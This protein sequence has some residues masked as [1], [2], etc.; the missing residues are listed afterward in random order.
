M[1]FQR[2][3]LNEIIERVNDDAQSRI[4]TT[5]MRRSNMKVY[6][7]VLA[8]AVHGLYG[9]ISF[10]N[11]QQFVDTAESDYLDRWASIWDVKRKQATAASGS[12]KFTFS[13][14]AVEIPAGTIL[15]SDDGVLYRTTDAATSAG[16]ALCEASVAGAEGNQT[17]G[18]VLTL[19][20][21]IA[22]V[23]SE[24]T[25]VGMAGGSD[26]EDDESLRSRLLLRMQETPHGGTASDYVKWALE[27]PGVTRAWCSPLEDGAGSVTVRFVCDNQS[28]SILPDE[29]MLQRVKTYIDSVRPVTAD[30][31][32]K[33]MSLKAVDITISGLEPDS[34]S[35]RAA[36]ESELKTLFTNEA[37]PGQRVYLSHI[38]AAISA[39]IGETDHT[40]D[41]P[42]SDPIPGTNELLT[43]GTITWL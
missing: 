5:Q 14:D 26:K 25:V 10:L 19:V 43:L 20:S 40:L 1:S 32:I 36:I 8:G 7:R 9:Y 13:S 31:S 17:A 35:V 37:A 33:A 42:T 4:G 38:R 3:T 6:T 28:G 39:A 18:D 15:Q 34:T 24:A 41:A 16:T 21:P 29:E 27:V 30:V 22:G 23:Y 12:V 11:R 2:P